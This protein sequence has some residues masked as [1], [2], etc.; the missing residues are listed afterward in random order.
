VVRLF[1]CFLKEINYMSD[2]VLL[3]G[4]TFFRGVQGTEVFARMFYLSLF[5]SSIHP[6]NC[7]NQ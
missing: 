1:K 3:T 4:F 5:F 6:N 2:V 7:S